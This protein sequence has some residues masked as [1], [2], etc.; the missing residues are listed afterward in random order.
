M[1]Q[2][3]RPRLIRRIIETEPTVFS[4][5][6]NRSETFQFP[7]SEEDLAFFSARPVELDRVR[8][9]CGKRYREYEFEGADVLNHAV[10]VRFGDQITRVS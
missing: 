3:T 4:Q 10:L 2:P 1:S 5:L 9:K 8:I 6:T 7:A